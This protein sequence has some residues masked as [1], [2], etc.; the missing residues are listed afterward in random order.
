VSEYSAQLLNIGGRW[1][2][3]E[4]LKRAACGVDC[5]ECGS[6]KVT[7][8]RDLNAAK[9]LVEWYRDMKWIEENEGAEAVLRKNPLCKG[10]WNTTED[11]FFRCGNSNECGLR[12]C[13]IEKQ[14]DHCGHCIDFPCDKYL[15]FANGHGVHKKAMDYLLSVKAN[16]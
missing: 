1:I 14:I 11:C 6:Y 10:C 2:I 13:C 3:M 15:D 4:K 7:M 5:T 16:S 12:T 9:D 8:E